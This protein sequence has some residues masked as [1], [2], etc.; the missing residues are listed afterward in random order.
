MRDVGSVKVW[1]LSF[2]AA[3]GVGLG[4]LI[5]IGCAVGANTCPFSG[6]EPFTSTDGEEIWLANC[7]LCHGVDGAGSDRNPNAPSLVSGPS[8]ELGL[9]ELIAQI[10][11][12]SPG[13]MPRYEGQLTDEQI[14]AVAEYVLSL[15]EGS[16]G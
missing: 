9:E 12:G 6:D 10:E 13:L 3:M 4:A 5:G 1:V 2:V 11:D 15:R 8:A 14:R 7:A 16:D